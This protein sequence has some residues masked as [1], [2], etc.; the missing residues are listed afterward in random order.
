MLSL[1]ESKRSIRKMPSNPAMISMYDA[2]GA[3]TGYTD[4][5]SRVMFQRL[6]DAHPEIAT[7]CRHEKFPG[8]RA[9]PVVEIRNIAMILALLPSAASQFRKELL[10]IAPESPEELLDAA[11]ILSERGCSQEQIGRL[12]G[13]LGKDLWLVAKSEAR[14]V[15]TVAMHFGP[16]TRE[17]KQ[18]SRVADAKLIDDVFQSF[19][20]R[21]LFKRAAADDPTTLQRQQLLAEQGRGRSKKQ[22]TA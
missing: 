16:E 10:D 8:Q 5:H 21:P 2:L 19:R 9:T 17:I 4:N 22:R 13:E 20:Q 1:L 18:Y 14:M 6:R 3:I 7:V 12:A 11:A 15:P